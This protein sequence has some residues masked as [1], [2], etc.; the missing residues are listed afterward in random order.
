MPY[1]ITDAMQDI[2]TLDA[3]VESLI[4]GLTNLITDLQKKGVIEKPKEQ[5][6]EA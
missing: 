6:Q 2:Q 5:H 1:D 3:K 4:Q